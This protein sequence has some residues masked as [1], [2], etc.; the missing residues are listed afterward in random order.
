MK[1]ISKTIKSTIHSITQLYY[2][3]SNWAKVLIIV[4]LLLIVITI[5]KT[6]KENLRLIIAQSLQIIAHVI[7]YTLF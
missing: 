6:Q 1:N 2:K 7:I 3:S 5:T 4:V